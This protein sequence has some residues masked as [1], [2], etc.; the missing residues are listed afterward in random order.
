M[1]WSATGATSYDVAFGTVNPPPP[2]TT[3][4]SGT[5]YTPPP[6]A[7]STTYF[8]QVT[9]R[10]AGGIDRRTR[11]DVYDGRAATAA[12]R[13]GDTESSEC[14]NRCGDDDRADLECVR[15]DHL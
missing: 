1:S 7:N 5:T 3:A 12:G 10:N 8:W 4:Q 11:L 9:A 15:R 2:V 14:R 6:M 13:A